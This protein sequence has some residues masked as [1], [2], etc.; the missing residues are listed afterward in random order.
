MARTIC[1]ECQ[2][3]TYLRYPKML[4]EM[5]ENFAS[6]RP[7]HVTRVSA[8]QTAPSLFVFREASVTTARGFCTNSSH[9]LHLETFAKTLF[10][11][12]IIH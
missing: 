1:W 11:W 9:R 7:L 12:S 10:V 8:W 4:L 3:R 5:L 2:D 6:D